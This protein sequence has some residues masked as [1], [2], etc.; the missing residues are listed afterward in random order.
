MLIDRDVIISVRIM[1]MSFSYSL[2]E[3]RRV[4]CQ[5]VLHNKLLVGP[6]KK[7]NLHL[8]AIQSQLSPKSNFIFF[9]QNYCLYILFGF[10][11][12]GFVFVFWW[13]CVAFRILVS[14]PGI[15]PITPVLGAWSLNHWLPEKSLYIFNTSRITSNVFQF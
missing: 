8:L 4:C 3:T 15:Q 7:W 14:Q 11:L 5:S 6:V 10:C 13:H 9:L 2:E 12:L 1:E